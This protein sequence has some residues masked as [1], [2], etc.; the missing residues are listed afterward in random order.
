[1]TLRQY[2]A[3]MIVST[4]VCW[5]GWVAVVR[6]IDPISGGVIGITLFYVSLALALIGTISTA[7][8]VIRARMHRHEAVSRHVI[9]ALRQSLLLSGTVIAGLLLQSH[10][11]FTGMNFLLLIGIATL[12]EF[13]LISLKNDRLSK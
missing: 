11:R 1:M 9:V 6:Y 2:L 13:F 3:L 7:G 4:A 10:G 12:A 8:L 5:F